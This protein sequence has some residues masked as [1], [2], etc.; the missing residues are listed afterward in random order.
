MYRRDATREAL[1]KKL[2]RVSNSSRRLNRGHAL[3]IMILQVYFALAQASLHGVVGPQRNN[4]VAARVNDLPRI[5][6]LVLVR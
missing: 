3:Y 4:V 1:V 5:L 6:Q 2:L